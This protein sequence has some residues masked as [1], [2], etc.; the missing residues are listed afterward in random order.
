MLMAGIVKGVS[1]TGASQQLSQ[2]RGRFG[3]VP[4]SVISAMAVPPATSR[5]IH[6]TPPSGGADLEA[7]CVMHAMSTPTL[8]RDRSRKGKT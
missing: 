8:G 5:A 1:E 6:L 7:T 2:A 3:R 4:L